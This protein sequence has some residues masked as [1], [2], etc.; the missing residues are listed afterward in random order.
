MTTVERAKKVA[1][2][3][4]EL[5]EAAR[6]FADPE[7]TNWPTSKTESLVEAAVEFTNA[8]VALGKGRNQ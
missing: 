3:V 5:Q 8:I 2:K 4:V 1:R 6:K 7:N